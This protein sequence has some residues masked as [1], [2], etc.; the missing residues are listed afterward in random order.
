[1]ANYDGLPEWV[2]TWT[3]LLQAAITQGSHD[4]YRR[5]VE[6]FLRWCEEEYPVKLYSIRDLDN[7]LAEYGWHVYETYGGRGKQRLINA[8]YGIE[9]FLPA[10]RPELV[11]GR[12]SITGWQKL[13]PPVSHPPIPWHLTTL[14]AVEMAKMGHAGA[15]IGLLLSFDCYLR[16][17]ELCSLRTYHISDL[18]NLAG[19][20]HD[21]GTL[22]S[23]AHCKTGNNQSVRIA[24]G[25]VQSLLEQWVR[26]VSTVQGEGSIL[27]PPEGLFRE[28]LHGAQERLGWHRDHHFVPHSCRHGGA[29]TDYMAVATRLEDILYRGRWASMTSTRRYIQ[30]GPALMAAAARNV[31]DWQRD[32]ARHL[33]AHVELFL[34]PFFPDPEF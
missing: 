33:A 10:T 29:T 22:V 18:Q 16:V 14:I 21:S 9:H 13:R 30:E 28:L 7:C 23:L 17:S 11:L 1:M 34:S 3:P 24:R 5:G 8:V 32:F 20:P 31:P 4:Q 15:G 26:Y 6:Q 27:F 19:D 2:S 12:R 25:S